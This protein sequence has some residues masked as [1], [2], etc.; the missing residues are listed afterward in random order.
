MTWR[1]Q[2][3]LNGADIA[4]R[5]PTP[6]AAIEAACQLID[7]GHEVTAIGIGANHTDSISRGEIA[8]IYAI[9]ASARQP[10]LWF[11]NRHTDESRRPLRAAAGRLVRS[12]A[13][14]RGTAGK[15]L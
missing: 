2:Y 13:D 12:D 1:V 3:S 8:K 11:S 5:F 14:S 10:A 4:A 15:R 7:C 9:W 6:E